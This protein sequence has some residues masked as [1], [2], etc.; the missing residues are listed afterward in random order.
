M[1]GILRHNTEIGK[2]VIAGDEK[3]ITNL[4]FEPE[5][6]LSGLED[7]K[8]SLLEEAAFQLDEYLSGKRKYFTLP[9]KPQGTPFMQEVWHH[10][11]SIPYGELVSYKEIAINLGNPYSYRAVALACHKNPLP[12]FIPCHR[13]IKS[14]GNLAGYKGG[15][16][17]KKKLIALELQNN[18]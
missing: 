14:D 16:E 8:S 11:L 10:L 12:I 5:P 7:K 6:F 9:L 1:R 15:L 18:A 4:Y 3:F 17:R 13:V 2:L